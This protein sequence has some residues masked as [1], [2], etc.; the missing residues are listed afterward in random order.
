MAAAASTCG[1]RRRTKARSTTSRSVTPLACPRVV[2]LTQFRGDPILLRGGGT[3]DVENQTA[4]RG[5]VPTADGRARSVRTYGPGDLARE[6]EPSAQAIRTWVAQ[7]NR[8]TG[9]R[10]DGPRTEEREEVRQLRREVRRLR[11]ERDILAKATAWFAQE[12]GPG[13]STGS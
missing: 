3:R 4:V 6:F 7:A 9:T 13:R 12:T 5:G 1:S 10:T 11:E 2:K 8:D